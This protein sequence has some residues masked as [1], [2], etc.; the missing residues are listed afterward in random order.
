MKKLTEHV[1]YVGVQNPSMRTFDIIM[2]TG[3]G[4]SYNS[5]VVRGEK[6]AVIET[7]HADYGKEFLAN[8]E[9]IL[10]AEKVDYVILNHTEPDHTGS[11]VTLLDVNP[12]IEVYGTVAAIRNVEAITNRKLNSHS[13]KTGEILDLGQGITLE[14]I[15]SPNLHWPDSMFTYFEKEQVLF[16]CD[17]FGSHYCEPEVLDCHVKKPE[18]LR[19]ERK[20]YYDCIFSPFQKFVRMGLDRIKD[21]KIELIC[22]SHGPVLKEYLQETLEDYRSWSATKQEEK[23]IA[24]FYVSAYGYTKSMAEIFAREFKKQSITVT[25]YDLSETSQEEAAEALHKA[26]AVLFG[27]PTINQDALKPIWDLISCTDAIH[28]RTAKTPALTFGSYGWSGEACGYL[29]ERLRTLKYK[30]VG[31]GVTCVFKPAPEDEARIHQAAQVVLDAIS[32]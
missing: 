32:E 25:Q 1:S 11:L 16:S 20:N 30:V 3:Y 8:I 18:L 14:F 21:K 28:V 2:K 7:A 24:I 4:S 31:D 5:Y 13:V 29:D 23:N 19:G 10:P 26:T 15:V 27:S 12:E 9:E 6:T 17:V 22:P